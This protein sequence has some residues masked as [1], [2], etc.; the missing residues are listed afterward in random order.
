MNK[1]L[2]KFG[3]TDHISEWKSKGLPDEVIKTPATTGNNLDPV[4]S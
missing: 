3:N 1:Y 2:K 4:L